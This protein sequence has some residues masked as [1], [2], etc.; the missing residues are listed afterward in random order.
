VSWCIKKAGESHFGNSFLVMQ[1]GINN[2][3]PGFHDY[4][5]G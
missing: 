5:F 3:H 2:F 1:N 4:M